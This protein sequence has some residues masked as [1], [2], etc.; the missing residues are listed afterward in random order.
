VT[1]IEAVAL[2]LCPWPFVTVRP[3]VDEFL[4][5]NEHVDPAHGN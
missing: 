3:T 1:W 4:D 2:E 5:S